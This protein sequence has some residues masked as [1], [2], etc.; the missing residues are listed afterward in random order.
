MLT[1]ATFARDCNGSEAA[2][3]RS[4]P[5]TIPCWRSAEVNLGTTQLAL[6]A[7]SGQE[8]NILGGA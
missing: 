8:S 2:L 5:L 3:G 6:T 1:E 7:A 4:K